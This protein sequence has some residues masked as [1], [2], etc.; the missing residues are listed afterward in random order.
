MFDFNF[1]LDFFLYCSTGS[2]FR[3]A[4]RHLIYK[5]L[6]FMCKL[7]C[8]KP[9]VNEPTGDTVAFPSD[10]QHSYIRQ[11]E[12]DGSSFKSVI[13]YNQTRIQEESNL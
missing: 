5:T 4:L 2:N 3:Q 10:R 6:Y 11:Y 12:G 8:N 1:A 9:P 13:R 7:K